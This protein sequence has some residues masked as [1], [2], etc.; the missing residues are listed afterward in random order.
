[1]NKSGLS[2]KSFLTLFKQT[3]PPLSK[4]K[5]MAPMKILF[6]VLKVGCLFILILFPAVMI[7]GTF[8]TGQPA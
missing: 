1:M 3:R 6:W 5:Q 8:S 2:L 7:Y 4:V